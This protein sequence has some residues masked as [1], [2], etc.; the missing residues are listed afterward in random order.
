MPVSFQGERDAA[1][2]NAAG[3]SLDGT[4]CGNGFDRSA[5]F[6]GYETLRE[7]DQGSAE[8][9]GNERRGD[10]RGRPVEWTAGCDLRDGVWIYRGVDGCGGRRKSDARD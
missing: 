3:R 1:A 8:K 5:K 10:H 9:T 2:G 4:R 6:R 7:T